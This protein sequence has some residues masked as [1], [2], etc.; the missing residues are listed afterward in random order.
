MTAIEGR[1]PIVETCVTH[2][3]PLVSSRL[4]SFVQQ[5]TQRFTPHI[6][7]AEVQA[8]AEPVLHIDLESVVVVVAIRSLIGQATQVRIGLEKVDRERAGHGE[9]SGDARGYFVADEAAKIRRAGGQRLG[10]RAR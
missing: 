3:E 1:W 6:V 9:T 5:V 10:E 8:I 7:D 2:G 4:I